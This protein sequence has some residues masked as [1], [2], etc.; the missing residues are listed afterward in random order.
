MGL[1]AFF[2]KKP[3]KRSEVFKFTNFSESF[4]Y[5]LSSVTLPCM[6]KFCP[7]LVTASI[8]YT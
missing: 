6:T 1:N 2:I 3:P 4:Y 5:Y 7:L 8:S